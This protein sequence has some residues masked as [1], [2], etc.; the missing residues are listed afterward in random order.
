MAT[1]DAVTLDEVKVS[2]ALEG[3]AEDEMLARL[4]SGVTLEVER[5]LGTQFIQRSLVEYHEGGSKRIYPQRA[6]I[7]TVTSLVDPAGNVIPATD[8]VIRQQRW[9]EHFG[10]FNPAQTTAGQV[11]DWT[12]TYTAGWFA[13]TSVV[14]AD[15]KHEMLRALGALR[16]SPAA[17]VS[18]VSVGD[19]SIN[20][21]QLAGST[22][23][24]NPAMD[25]CIASL[26]AYRGVLL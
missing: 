4:I 3:T 7:I 22:V 26:Y 20:Y 15:V 12:V 24:T 25:E 17:G 2:L 16:E 8:Y 11:T 5:R 6:P 9:L 10:H 1:Y 23:P 18:S 19:L 14:A 21:G 13:S